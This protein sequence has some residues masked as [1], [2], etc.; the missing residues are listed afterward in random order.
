MAKQGDK[1]GWDVNFISLNERQ[2]SALQI[3]LKSMSDEYR[4]LMSRKASAL[5]DIKGTRDQRV[6]NIEDTKKTWTEFV[7]ALIEDKDF[8]KE[9][10]IEI[11]KYR[12]AMEEEYNRL[13]QEIV[14][15]NGIVDKPLLN[16]ETI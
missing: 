1:S 8:R 16:S 5:K 14:Y 4:D 13:S 11:E 3:S 9:A 6:K 12:L 7:S 2:I 15:N 10:G